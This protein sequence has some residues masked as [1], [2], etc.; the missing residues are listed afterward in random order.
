MDPSIWGTPSI[1]SVRNDT[2]ESRRAAGFV[3]T[4]G[5]RPGRVLAASLVMTPKWQNP[6]ANCPCPPGRHLPD[7]PI[8]VSL[9]ILRL[10]A[11]GEAAAFAVM[12]FGRRSR[13][14]GSAPRRLGAW[15]RDPRL[16]AM[17]HRRSGEAA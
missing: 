7:A 4:S 12:R 8:V 15:R 9:W 5:W 11:K 13:R 10:F 17:E 3:P 2:L 6:A 14:E 1:V 16:C